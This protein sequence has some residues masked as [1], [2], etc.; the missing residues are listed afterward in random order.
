MLWASN[1][2]KKTK[3][4]WTLVPLIL[5]YPAGFLFTYLAGT[6]GFSTAQKL[7]F[8]FPENFIGKAIVIEKMP[9]GQPKKIINGRE[10]LYI[11]ENGILLY[12]GELETGYVNHKYYKLQANG[13]KIEIPERYHY[14]Y[15]DSEKI[16][17][18]STVVGAW[19]TENG[20]AYINDVDRKIEYNFMNVIVSSKDSLQ[21]YYEFDYSK[22][23]EEGVDSLVRG[24]R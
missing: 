22:K 6:I 18:D 8:V 13:Q 14:M 7:E 5:W 20:T 23:L 2:P 16:K 11:P 12:Q 3:L 24:C 17:P 15:F 1:S 4:L 10:Q 19:L 9:C 21:K